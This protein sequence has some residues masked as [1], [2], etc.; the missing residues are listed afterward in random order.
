MDRSF[1]AKCAIG[2]GFSAPAWIIFCGLGEMVYAVCSQCT[3][4]NPRVWPG[5]PSICFGTDDDE[6][7]ETAGLG[8]TTHV[9]VQRDHLNKLCLK[10]GLLNSPPKSALEGNFIKSAPDRRIN[11]HANFHYSGLECFSS[12]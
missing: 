4:S 10:R 3:H 1:A 5:M 8:A 11:R 6:A 9:E 2:R 12:C 7:A